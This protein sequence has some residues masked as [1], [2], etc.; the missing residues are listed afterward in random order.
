MPLAKAEILA[1]RHPARSENPVAGAIANATVAN[2]AKSRSK[3]SGERMFFPSMCRR[4]P[5]RFYA[6]E[7]SAFPRCGEAPQLAPHEQEMDIGFRTTGHF[8]G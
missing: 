1:G 6:F 7:T 8:F 4:S 3:T 2:L 5:M